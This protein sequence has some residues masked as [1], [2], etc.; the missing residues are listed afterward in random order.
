MALLCADR[1]ARRSELT[2]SDT[3]RNDPLRYDPK[4]NFFQQVNT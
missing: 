4:R 3:T 2:R 1:I